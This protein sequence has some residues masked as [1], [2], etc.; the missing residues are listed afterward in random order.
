MLHSNYGTAPIPRVYAR[1]IGGY[2]TVIPW[3][4]VNPSGPGLPAGPEYRIHV[5]KDKGRSGWWIARCPLHYCTADGQGREAA[6]RALVARLT[7]IARSEAEPAIV[8]P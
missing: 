2:V 3:H 5:G 6:V 1:T 4:H 7:V 8:C